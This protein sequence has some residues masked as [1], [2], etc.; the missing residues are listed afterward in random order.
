MDIKQVITLALQEDVGDGDHT[1]L[2]VVPENAMGEVLMI[3]KQNGII[4]G[5]KVAALVFKEVDSN[6]AIT[7]K[8]SD[9]RSIKNGDVL[10]AI[11]GKSQSLLTAERTA[12]NFIQRMS[13]IATFTHKLVTKLDGLN[14]KILDTR[15]T[16]PCNRIIEKMA[17]KAG[18]GYNHRFGL[19]DMIMIK[20]NHVDFAGGIKPAIKATQTYLERIR[21]NLKIEI[22]VRNF[23]ELYQVL[24]LGSVHRIMLDNFSPDDLFTAIKIIDKQFETEASGGINFENIREYAETG[25][26]FV[27]VGALTHQIKSLDISLKAV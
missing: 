24:Q 5:A 11:S 21:K 26:D 13:G 4:A 18:G 20:D 22:E 9:G 10:M 23:N 2:A 15:K 19:Y 25:V 14:T 1:T 27:S 7:L 12:L 3:A 8:T 17:V 16:T 6:L